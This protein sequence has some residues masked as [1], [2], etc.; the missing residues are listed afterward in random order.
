M[1][2]YRAN[3]ES[4]KYTQIDNTAVNDNRLS[5]KARGILLYMLSRP[6]DWQFYEDEISGHS[7]EGIKSIRAGMNELIACGY[8]NRTQKREKGQFSKYEYTV[9][10]VPK[11]HFGENVQNEADFTEV[12][13]SEVRKT[14]IAKWHTT[15]TEYTK[16]DKTN[17][18]KNGAC[19]PAHHYNGSSD[20]EHPMFFSLED[21]TKFENADSDIANFMRWYGRLYKK[22]KGKN[23]P[24]LK[25]EQISKVHYALLD[26][27][28]KDNEC[29]EN[30]T[31]M[32][33]AAILYFE[34]VKKCDYNINHFATEG[35]REMREYELM[36]QEVD[37]SLF[38][39]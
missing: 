1:A 14:E 27:Y 34:N 38:E 26:Q 28:G 7:C 3:K 31:M 37:E 12:P 16:T 33:S 39:L 36:S 15:N 32:Q 30:I 5:F 19:A 9:T 24:R 13:F 10:E 2:I 25:K 20:D 29:Y 35:I 17:K 11:R 23:H 8:V 22:Y 4:G 21:I 6:D 18:E